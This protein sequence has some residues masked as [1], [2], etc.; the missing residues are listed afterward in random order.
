MRYFKFGSRKFQSH[1]QRE[2]Q[3][4]Q[5]KCELDVDRSEDPEKLNEKQMSASFY[6]PEAE[7]LAYISF[8]PSEI[9]L[10]SL[11]ILVKITTLKNFK[12]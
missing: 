8:I 9:F 3:K 7:K 10:I 2:I 1:S 4:Y 11:E 6:T 12:G 5:L